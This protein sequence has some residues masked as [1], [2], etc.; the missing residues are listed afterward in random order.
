MSFYQANVA[1]S[2]RGTGK[3]LLMSRRGGSCALV[4][5]CPRGGRIEAGALGELEVVP[6][7]YLYQGSAFGPGGIRARCLRHW[8]GGR[9]RWHMD[10][11][12]PLCRLEL[13]WFTHE[14]H[15]REHEWTGL[16]AALPE[17]RLPFSGFGASDCRCVSHLVWLP[18]PPSADVLAAGGLELG[19]W[20]PDAAGPGA[21]RP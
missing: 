21:P 15:N 4:L 5:Q 10:Y 14:L 13:V 6:G 17:A 11:L 7:F 12:R 3:S 8:R 20:V 2:R 1:A 18:R 9:P 19:V 16:L